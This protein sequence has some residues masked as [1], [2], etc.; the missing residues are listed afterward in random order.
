MA[1]AP[2]HESEQLCFSK[3]VILTVGVFGNIE[4][5][6]SQDAVLHRVFASIVEEAISGDLGPKPIVESILSLY[7][8]Y[9]S[10]GWE[11]ARVFFYMLTGQLLDKSDD[12]P[13]CDV[14]ESF[15]ETLYGHIDSLDVPILDPRTVAGECDKH[16]DVLNALWFD[17]D[18]YYDNDSDSEA[19]PEEESDSD[20]ES[21][22]PDD[23]SSVSSVGT[24]DG[25]V[26]PRGAATAQ[27]V[28]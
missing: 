11:A 8:L 12:D 13:K 1:Q 26:D 5:A 7:R 24:E 28:E 9:Y 23:A 22:M 10:D 6:A 14:K 15:A 3:D 19:D 20:D 2:I 17:S 25:V 21:T 4:D 18:A 27:F 16:C